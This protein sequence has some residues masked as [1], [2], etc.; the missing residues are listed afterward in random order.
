MSILF[1]VDGKVEVPERVGAG[2][3]ALGL[4]LDVGGVS[5]PESEVED[6]TLEDAHL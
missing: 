5:K 1:G 4:K 2:L 6:V 3:E